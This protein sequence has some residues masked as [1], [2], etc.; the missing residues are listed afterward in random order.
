[1]SIQF[2]KNDPDFSKTLIEALDRTVSRF[3]DRG[4]AHVVTS[5][6]PEIFQSYK[7][8]MIQ[9]KKFARVLYRKGIRPQDKV[10]LVL[11]KSDVFLTTFWGCLL[12]GIVP[13]PL[14]SIRTPKPESM[15]VKRLINV[16][17]VLHA[18]II[19]DSRN[20]SSFP[21]LKELFEEKRIRILAADEIIAEGE[22]TDFANEDIYAAKP[23]DLAIIQF[24]SAS[25]GLPKGAELTHGNLISNIK[26][27]LA[28]EQATEKDRYINWMPYFHDFGLFG[29]HLTPLVAGIEQVK[30][31]PMHFARNPLI[32]LKK[33]H[34]HRSTITGSTNTGIQFLVNFLVNLIENK[35][36]DLNIDLSCLRV[37]VVGAEMISLRACK[38]F[39]ELLA[40]YDLRP[41][42]FLFGY[43]LTETTLVATFQPV[44]EMPISK[45]LD[46]KML[47]SKGI[48]EYRNQGD[49]DTIEFADVGY[50]VLECE[51]RI[52]DGNGNVLPPNR[53]GIIEVRGK[54]VSRGYYNNPEAN[55]ELF[56]GN[57][58][59][60]GDLG[61][62]DDKGRL[63]ITGRA[64]E[65]I[66][67]NGQN[68]FPYD[69]EE[70]AWKVADDKFKQIVVCGFYDTE[71]SKEKVLLFFALKKT[72][73]NEAIPTLINIKNQVNE[74][75]GFPIDHFIPMQANKIPR[76]SSGKIWRMK[77]INDFMEGMFK[78]QLNETQ[79]MLNQ[80]QYQTCDRSTI[81]HESV[82]KKIWS[83]ELGLHIDRIGVNKS[84]FNLGVDSILAMKIQGHL[85]DYYKI[86]LE[87]N[88]NYQYPTIAK[89]VRYFK[90]RDFSIEPPQNELE[91]ILQS[92]IA[93]CLDIEKGKLGVTDDFVARVK[94]L[95]EAL[96]IS[97]EIKKVFE[98]EFIPSEISK[99][100]T[101]RQMAEYL[102]DRFLNKKKGSKEPFPVMHFQETLY[103]HRKGFIRNEPSGLSCYI[104]FRAEMHGDFSLKAFNKAFN[105]VINRHPSLRAVIDEEKDSPRLKVLENVPEFRVKYKDI[106]HRD[107][108][109]QEQFLELK[110]IENNDYRFPVSR[111]PL[112]FSEVYKVDKKKHIFMMNIDH[113]LCDGYS[114]MH[115]LGELF[116]T[117]D[118]LC[119]AEPILLP[120]LDMEFRDYV[121]IEKLRQR[122]AEYKEAMDFQLEIFK[123]IPPKATLPFKQ[124]PALIKDVF[125]NTFFTFLDPAL[126]NTLIA[127]A[128]HNQVSLNSILLAAYFKLMNIW[129][130]QDDLI[131]NMPIFNREHYF[132]G[133]RRVIGSF[134]DIFPVRLQTRIDESIMD[135]AKKVERFTREFLKVQVSSIEL[136]RLIAQRDGSPATSLGSIIFS[137]S[138]NIYSGEFSGLKTIK[139]KKLS[140]RTGAPGTF[141]D[142]VMW[143]FENEFH[144]EWNY[145]RDLF[146]PQFIETLAEQYKTLLKHLSEAYKSNRLFERFSGEG[147][148][149]RRH[150]ELLRKV[151]QTEKEYP[152]T[153]LHE[154]I[155]KQVE[156]IPDNLA[157]TFE[158]KCVTYK[159]LHQQSNQVAHLLSKVVVKPNEFVALILNRS[160]DMIV[161]QLGVLKA[162]GAYLP[163]DPTYPYERINYMLK[164]S[165]AKII[166]TQACYIGLLG[167][168]GTE[169][170]TYCLISDEEE[171]QFKKFG[172]EILN[173]DH[174]SAQ[175]TSDLLPTS[176]PEDLMYMI[177]TSG[178]TG[179][180]KGTMV[181]RRNF[182]NFI[183]YVQQEFNICP[184][185]HFALI[186]SYSFDMTL[187][188]NWVPF[189]SGSSL[190]ILSEEKTQDVEQLI[191]FLSK[192][193]ITFLNVTPSHF[194]L[195][196]NAM[197]HYEMDVKLRDNMTIMLGAEIINVSDLN[198]WL[199]RYPTHRFINEYGPTETTVAS[200]FFPIPVNSKNICELDRVPIGKPIYNTQIYI[201]NEEM[202]PCMVGVTGD[203]YIAGTGVSKGYLNKPGKTEAA[204]I[205]NPFSDA[206]EKMYKTGDMA[207]FLEDGNIEFLGRKDHQVNL[208]GFRIELGEIEN[209]LTGY[210][211]ISEAVV[212][213]RKDSNG[214][215]FLV[216]F[217][218]LS[219]GKKLFILA[220]RQY[221]SEKLPDY[222]IP[223]QFH[224]LEKLPLTPSGKVDRNALPD[225]TVKAHPE[226]KSR[227]VAP[228]TEPGK[229]A[230]KIW[231]EVLGT[232]GLGIHD[233]FWE[234]G[235]DSLRAMR[236]IQAMRNAGFE[237]FGLRDVFNYPTVAAMVERVEG[238]EI[239]EDANQNIVKLKSLQK[240]S[241]RLFCLPYAAGN[242]GM[243]TGL[244]KLLPDNFEVVSAQLPGHGDDKEPLSSIEDVTALYAAYL[245]KSN[246][247]PL[248]I[249]G[250][251]YGGYVAHD[252]A[253]ALEKRGQSVRGL[254]QVGVTPPNVK[255]ELMKFL[256][257]NVDETVELLM[258]MAAPDEQFINTM[259][260][261]EI[262]EYIEL[263]KIDTHA[264]IDYQWDKERILTPTI[265]LNGKDEED[266]IIR[267]KKEIWKDYCKNCSF[268]DLPGRHLLIKTH[269][270]AFAD[271]IRKFING[272]LV[273]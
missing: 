94:N 241:V 36:T 205:P 250:Y 29:C 134:I 264:M 153:T 51:L 188:S 43:G 1:M 133:A 171:P 181:C 79:K 269:T 61:F 194:S 225:I 14:P 203:M 262:E 160:I 13:S 139:L 237:K 119:L 62:I 215:L 22:I 159:E 244:S 226:L 120:K 24:S 67:V 54:N 122:T 157:V 183:Y 174:V 7:E 136:S 150:Q 240:L 15:E 90:E 42:V 227:Y 186:T 86:K 179:K 176:G 166:I 258:Q 116:N 253:R 52:V 3:P 232:H 124:N 48:V 73:L 192:K 92:I 45:I 129:C 229:K 146:E 245:E 168:L 77:L 99:Y 9:A 143:D 246:D 145:V 234:I 238:M 228:R 110:E 68:Y 187:T 178:S 8:L 56:N 104:F 72:K 49:P 221:L 190:H 180:P 95:S 189:I 167:S 20:Q 163:I 80:Y 39:T 102:Q 177:Y 63:C 121:Q 212:A 247:I 207:R 64:K 217:Y 199:G 93:K 204:F 239:S 210:E 248:F 158:D 31:D 112:F 6:G 10:I 164:D 125:F 208:R 71:E 50:P 252:L 140:Y 169:N 130:H 151:N 249:L 88:Y 236:L 193:E 198:M 132:P 196:V 175:P 147:I 76:T 35:K 231:E 152:V 261:Q 60:T 200:T 123:D 70:V 223:V 230:V 113:L 128:N 33:I 117:Y 144:F 197:N 41:N 32:W 126:M 206:D 266:P 16:W 173:K 235:G 83:E 165:G 209:A 30:I 106:S 265:F 118:K 66:I 46:R 251:S 57:W 82:I 172:F 170:V 27:K 28:A 135:I 34:Q 202:K 185:E 201:L 137:N 141:L 184:E 5:D 81:D 18:T 47:I 259:S 26:A 191:S 78:D 260:E 40:P 101:I 111:Y 69:I 87:T 213:T 214:Q 127:I 105:I 107:P 74:L 75:V 25:T 53:V 233:N 268:D 103:F 89:Q 149:S 19:C 96:Q 254:I 4:I 44:Y 243:Y 242:A 195:I 2:D 17:D 59:S 131:I 11:S 216:A 211:I 115:I 97:E 155:T 271:R 98:M 58:L 273:S 256:D 65:I 100:I 12:G 219:P 109:Q 156:K 154:W 21:L 267:D 114:Q 55:K 218:T 255:D 84:L 38:K 257:M 263:L 85:E 108:K 91:V 138:I 161:G 182:C 23:D 162:G 142:L 37:V 148:V 272:I 224:Y 222:M 220:L 270:E